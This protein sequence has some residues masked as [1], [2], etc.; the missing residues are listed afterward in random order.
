MNE[1]QEQV[2]GVVSYMSI[3]LI[4]LVEFCRL[5]LKKC[6][7]SPILSYLWHI[8]PYFTKH[9]LQNCTI[10]K[11]LIKLVQ[12]MLLLCFLFRY[13]LVSENKTITFSNYE[14]SVE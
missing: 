4:F 9:H 14:G 11:L 1:Q 13:T 6:N 5:Y 12:C 10:R 7:V 3:S 8:I 2:L